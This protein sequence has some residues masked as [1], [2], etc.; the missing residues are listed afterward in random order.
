M[1]NRP[2]V[3]DLASYPDGKWTLLDRRTF[4]KQDELEE[5]F[6]IKTAVVH[7]VCPMLSS[8]TLTVVKILAN[9]RVEAALDQFEKTMA[10]QD[11]QLA[12]KLMTSNVVNAPQRLLKVLQILQAGKSLSI[13]DLTG[14]TLNVS[15]VYRDTTRKVYVIEMTNVPPIKIRKSKLQEDLLRFMVD[16]KVD[17][18]SPSD[19]GFTLNIGSATVQFNDFT[20]HSRRGDSKKVTDILIGSVLKGV[21]QHE[22]NLLLSFQFK[23]EL[24][25]LSIIGDVKVSGVDQFNMS[26]D[27]KRLAL[28]KMLDSL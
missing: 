7:L 25:V 5:I 28:L 6:N 27:E 23:A 1:S 24:Y 10:T 15:K 4:P 16:S 22:L 17:K 18:V 9:T 3:G 26:V 19:S 8:E 2:I 14:Q 13:L 20:L 12:E 21:R 11:P